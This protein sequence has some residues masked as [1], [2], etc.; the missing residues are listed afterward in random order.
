MQ[1]A[2]TQTDKPADLELI[3]G[4]RQPL[5][6]TGEHS[7]DL[8]ARRLVSVVV[9]PQELE[10]DGGPQLDV[11]AGIGPQ[12]ADHRRVLPDDRLT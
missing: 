12:R 2:S 1:T 8:G 6:P 3:D 7:R 9:A 4:K 11:V 10:T 5:A